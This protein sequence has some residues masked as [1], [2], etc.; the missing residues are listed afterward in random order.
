[1]GKGPIWV[2]RRLLTSS[3]KDGKTMASWSQ[4]EQRSGIGAETGLLGPADKLLPHGHPYCH[5]PDKLTTSF[6]GP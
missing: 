2:L 6:C 3:F 1:M 4:K 5:C